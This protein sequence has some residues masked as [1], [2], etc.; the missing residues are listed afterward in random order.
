M[1][2]G[3]VLES[4]SCPTA[5]LCVA[6]TFPSTVVVSTDPAG[7]TAAWHGTAYLGYLA[8]S[9]LGVTCA[10]PALCIASGADWHGG[11]FVTE[12]PASGPWTPAGFAG[13]GTN[14][15]LAADCP[16]A[17]RCFATDDAGRVL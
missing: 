11:I 16:S 2:I 12:S 5:S 9:A 7:G 17:T 15:L 13:M 6:T 1:P 3:H 14:A 4:L 8:A 10:S